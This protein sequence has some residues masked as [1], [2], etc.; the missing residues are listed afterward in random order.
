MQ[1][2]YSAEESLTRESMLQVSLGMPGGN[3]TS[4]STSGVIQ[5]GLM[6]GGIDTKESPKQNSS[7]FVSNSPNSVTS[8]DLMKF[9][10]EDIASRKERSRLLSHI[11]NESSGLLGS[12]VKGN[13]PLVGT[14]NFWNTLLKENVIRSSDTRKGKYVENKSMGTQ[15]F[16]QSKY[17][18]DAKVN[19]SLPL[20]SRKSVTNPHLNGTETFLKSGKRVTMLNSNVTEL[21]LPSGKR[22]TKTTPTLTHSVLSSGKV[23]TMPRKDISKMNW[24]LSDQDENDANPF[25]RNLREHFAKRRKINEEC[26]KITYFD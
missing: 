8:A 2:Q 13:K 9:I 1:T 5:D 15:S 10:N 11:E 14:S 7:Q 3:L 20:P 12:I 18:D 22:V 26:S 16:L 6:G 4:N 25:E 17:V 21:I 23:A 19:H 24:N